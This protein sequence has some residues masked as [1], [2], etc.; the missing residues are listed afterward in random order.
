MSPTAPHGSGRHHVEQVMGMAV[1]IDIRDPDCP[2]AAVDEVVEWL[3]HV[4]DTFSTHKLDSPISAMGR[5]ELTLPDASEEIREV[6][7]LCERMR[8]ETDGAFD[9]FEVPAPNGTRLDPSGLVKGWAIE[10]AAELLESHG[11]ANFCVNAGGDIALR[12]HPTG[13]TPWRVGIRHPGR[14]DALA[15]VIEAEDRLA[16]A[17]SATYERGAHIFDPRTGQ[18]TTG[19]ASATVVGP[20]LTIADSYATAVFVMGLD[21]LEWIENRPGYDAYIITHDDETAWSSGFSR[22]QAKADSAPSP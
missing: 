8:L 10:R 20:D 2:V 5:G 18:P 12:G 11:S 21:A 7:R 6:L 19:L 1:S 14:P 15:L 13:T 3:H 9:I 4:D 17:T 22:Y 16:V